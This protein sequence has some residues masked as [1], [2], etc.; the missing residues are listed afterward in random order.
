M[1]LV[2][3]ENIVPFV[4]LS[5]SLCGNS[6]G[7]TKAFLTE[8]AASLAPE[9]RRD[10]IDVMV[11]RALRLDSCVC[12]F[13]GVPSSS[14]LALVFVFALLCACRRCL[15][16]MF[17]AGWVCQLCCSHNGAAVGARP[18]FH[19]SPVATRFYDK[20]HKFGALEMFKATAVTP[21]KIA[22]C[23]LA[24]VGHLVVRDQGYYPT[25]MRV[26]LKIMD[27]VFLTEIIARTAHT[28]ADFKKLAP[29]PVSKKSN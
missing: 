19:P 25:M 20:A 6:Y 26:L 4:L 21:G 2:S 3:L 18:Q 17:A 13:C 24:S 11:V 5:R 29:P 8:F 28:S 15:L 14:V 9:V 10:G 22:D 27:S 12:V 7:S 23:M 16:Y 1:H